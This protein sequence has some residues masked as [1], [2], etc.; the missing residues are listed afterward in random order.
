MKQLILVVE[1][2]RECLSDKIY[3]NF[4]LKTLYS[5]DPLTKIQWVLMDGN[6]NYKSEEVVQSINDCIS[7]NQ[8][9]PNIVI[10]VLDED[11]TAKQ[12]K[13]VK[14]IKGYC[15]SSGYETVLFNTSIEH[16]LLGQRISNKKQEKAL[17]FISTDKIKER[18]SQLRR[19]DPK[20]GESNILVVLDKY[21]KRKKRA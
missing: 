9:G 19:S 1:T 11:V 2:N 3:I 14:E 7:M 4:I 15:A 18:V 20:V 8:K 5:A 6:S 17:E 16:V 10:Y 12:K 13:K 21:L